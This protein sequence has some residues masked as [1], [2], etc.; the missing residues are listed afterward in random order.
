MRECL[1]GWVGNSGDKRGCTVGWVN[2]GIW[3]FA[4]LRVHE[5]VSA[6]LLGY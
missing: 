2:G 4:Y 6:W 5:F 1:V 3:G